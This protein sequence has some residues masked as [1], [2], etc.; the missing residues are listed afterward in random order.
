MWN[1]VNVKTPSI[2]QHKKDLFREP[3]SSCDD[4]KLH[5]LEKFAQ[6][7]ETWYCSGLP[8]LSKETCLAVKHTSLALCDIAKYLLSDLGFSYVL[9]GK[10]QSDVL[11]SR[12]G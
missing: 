6:F 4:F 9:L 12:F 2:G 11:E 1:I 7:I 10:F 3:I 8:C 5:Y